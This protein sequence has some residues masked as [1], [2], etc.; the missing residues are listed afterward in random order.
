MTY[1]YVITNRINEKQYVGK[2]DDY[3]RRFREHKRYAGRS[4]VHLALGKYGADNFDFDV[5]DQVEEERA[6]ELED[7][8]I[9]QWKTMVPCG[10]NL[11]N[12]G[13]GMRHHESSKIKMSEAHKGKVITM[14][15]RARM[16]ASRLGSLNPSW[17]KINA[18]AIPV[19]QCDMQS[20]HIIT[21]PSARHAAKH[22]QPGLDNKQISRI[23]CTINRCARGLTQ[24]AF[25]FTMEKNWS[26]FCGHKTLNN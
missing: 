3:E 10:Y 2:T 13:G 26:V 17:G 21:F 19:T 6:G 14:K 9:D 7:Y 4:I 11:K 12:G 22:L 18:R 20:T 16:S 5:I 15:T 1:I 24:S 23:S 25:G 8:Y